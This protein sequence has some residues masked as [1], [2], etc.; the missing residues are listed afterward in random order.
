M[1]DDTL[2]PVGATVEI[3]TASDRRISWRLTEVFLPWRRAWAN[4]DGVLGDPT[5][6]ATL[7]T[8]WHVQ[9]ERDQLDAELSA[10]RALAVEAMALASPQSG[11]I[12]G[13]SAM[14]HNLRGLV[15]RLAALA[16]KEA[17]DAE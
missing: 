2:P 9:Q 7:N 12:V 16:P 11:Q 17:S 4:A 6:H 14:H 15:A 13:P 5:L 10:F 3:T 8:L 1:S